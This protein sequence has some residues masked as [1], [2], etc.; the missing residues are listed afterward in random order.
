MANLVPNLD[1]ADSGYWLQLRPLKTGKD[2]AEAG[3]QNFALVLWRR[4]VQPGQIM[5]ICGLSGFIVPVVWVESPVHK[6]L[7][8]LARR[9]LSADQAYWSSLNKDDQRM[10]Q[11]SHV[12][13]LASQPHVDE[14][15]AAIDAEIAK[16]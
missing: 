15:L 5:E 1:L 7:Y 10:L 12:R 4:G 2:D 16:R 3:K 14:F 8:A 11:P 13:W 6:D 9:W